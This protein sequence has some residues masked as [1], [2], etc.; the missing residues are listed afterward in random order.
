MYGTRFVAL[1]VALT[2]CPSDTSN[3]PDTTSTG[4]A[5]TPTTTSDTTEAPASTS[6][7]TGL[8]PTTGDDTSDDTARATLEVTTGPACLPGQAVVH[9][10]CVP[11]PADGEAA[12]C[13]DHEVPDGQTWGACPDGVCMNGEPCLDLNGG[14][15]CPPNDACGAGPCDPRGCTG[16]TCYATRCVPPCLTAADCPYAGMVCVAFDGG[17]ICLWPRP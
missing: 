7:S 12:T 14:T 8:A 15:L 6:T 10:H 3:A 13:T 5:P 1:V 2:A 17:P 11:W 9:D 16:G 4:P